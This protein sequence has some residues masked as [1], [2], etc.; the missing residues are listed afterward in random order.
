HSLPAAAITP[1][2]SSDL[3]GNIATHPQPC[4]VAGN[5]TSAYKRWWTGENTTTWGP[6]DILGNPLY[7]KIAPAP[8]TGTDLHTAPRSPAIGRGSPKFSPRKDIDGK[9]R[10][11]R[12]RPDIGASQREDARIVLG[13]SIGEVAL[14]ATD[15]DVV[16]FY[17]TPRHSRM[18]NSLKYVDYRRHGGTLGITYNAQH[19]VVAVVTTSVYYLTA[20]GLGPGASSRGMSEKWSRCGRFRWTRISGK[21]VRIT[22]TGGR[23]RRISIDAAPR[24][25]C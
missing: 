8:Q 2:T 16:R 25:A 18:R 12:W 6:G 13:R 4:A 21:T 7:T 9:L 5:W 19:R 15:A 23:I 24:R 3:R 11:R 10:P 17:G 14:G 1:T 20:A 22:V